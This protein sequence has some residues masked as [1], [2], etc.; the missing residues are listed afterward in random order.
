MIKL[1][2]QKTNLSKAQLVRDLLVEPWIIED[3]KLLLPRSQ[4]SFLSQYLEAVSEVM[5]GGTALEKDPWL[6][7]LGE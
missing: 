7:Q 4:T 3:Y 1:V 5:S 2:Y 6:V